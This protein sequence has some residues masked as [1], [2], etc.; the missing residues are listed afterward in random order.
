VVLHL[1]DP[2]TYGSSV[3]QPQGRALRRSGFGCA[4]GRRWWAGL[5]WAALSSG[6]AGLPG[7]D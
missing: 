7:G 1:S 2:T 3:G 4:R 5:A 6:R